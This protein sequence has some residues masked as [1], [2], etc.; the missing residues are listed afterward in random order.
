[1]PINSARLLNLAFR[2]LDDEHGISESAWITL[3]P[4]LF[5]IDCLTLISKVISSEGRFFLPRTR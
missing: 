5:E 3:K 4:M 2:L 1:M